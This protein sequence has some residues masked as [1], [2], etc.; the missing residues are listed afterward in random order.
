MRLGTGRVCP[1]EGKPGPTDPAQAAT[2]VRPLPAKSAEPH[3]LRRAAA[4]NVLLPAPLTYGGS[5]DTLERFRCAAVRE[6]FPLIQVRLVATGIKVPLE[7]A[8]GVSLRVRRR[9]LH[10]HPDEPPAIHDRTS[11]RFGDNEF[12]VVRIESPVRVQFER[13][14]DRS[15]ANGPLQPLLMVDGLL[16]VE[17]QQDPTAMLVDNDHWT[18][19]ATGQSWSGL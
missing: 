14:G 15:E 17:G 8:P 6:S 9:E 1:R 11:W 19:S 13:D 16:Y 18:E 2:A 5:P 3:A 10:Y 12:H 7:P 4:L